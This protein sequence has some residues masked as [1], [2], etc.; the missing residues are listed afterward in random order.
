[1]DVGAADA[2]ELDG[3][4][5]AV[6]AEWR[7]L[8]LVRSQ[9]RARL[10]G[11]VGLH[12]P[13]LVRA[14]LHASRA[15]R[16]SDHGHKRGCLDRVL[17]NVPPRF[18]P[19]PRGTLASFCIFY[20]LSHCIITRSVALFG[21]HNST[22]LSRLFA[23]HDNTPQRRIL[24]HLSHTHTRRGRRGTHAHAHTHSLTSQSE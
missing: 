12:S 18:R 20:Y 24:D 14:V 5:D 7:R 13:W 19:H 8:E 6:R 2:A 3:D 21:S 9:L 17:A 1:M 22:H 23:S 15:S 10:E 4:L 16:W 11:R